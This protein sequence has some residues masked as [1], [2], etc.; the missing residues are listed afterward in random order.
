MSINFGG[1]QLAQGLFNDNKN[2]EIS[3]NFPRKTRSSQTDIPQSVMEKIFSHPE[4]KHT[5]EAHA[6]GLQKKCLD[7]EDKNAKT[8]MLKSNYFKNRTP[9]N[10]LPLNENVY[11][12]NCTILCDALKEA[13]SHGD[14]EYVLA[15][16]E[17]ELKE[18]EPFESFTYSARHC[19][20][21]HFDW[22]P[23]QKTLVLA[24]KHGHHLIVEK[25]MNS[26]WYRDTCSYYR[27][28]NYL[29]GKALNEA[30]GH[31]F[32]N[33]VEEI[34]KHKEDLDKYLSNSELI[35]AIQNSVTKIHICNS[36]KYRE[37][38]DRLI[39]IANERNM[40]ESEYAIET[41]VLG[42]AIKDLSD[43]GLIKAIQNSTTRIHIY[44]SSEYREIKD[45]LIAIANERNIP[46]SEYAIKTH[47]LVVAVEDGLVETAC[48][49]IN[50]PVFN[51]ISSSDLNK[52]WNI[53]CKKKY[54]DIVIKLIE[55]AKFSEINYPSYSFEWEGFAKAFFFEDK[56][57]IR[58]LIASNR[59]EKLGQKLL[60]EI[61]ISLARNHLIAIKELINCSRFQ[62][63]KIDTLGKALLENMK[64]SYDRI[65]VDQTALMLINNSKFQEIS[66]D[67]LGEFLVEAAGKS[68]EVTKKLMD[69]SRFQEIKAGVLAKALKKAANYSSLIVKELTTSNRFTE[70]PFPEI[71]EI[72]KMYA[73]LEDQNNSGL[74]G[75]LTYDKLHK[76]HPE[77]F[78]S[79]LF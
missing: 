77:C 72:I 10:Q 8:V 40:P 1:Q 29:V 6:Y 15:I 37:I 64:S 18:V 79:T 7:N 54:V 4:H 62:E 25:L 61:F 5:L 9:L 50:S 60:N 33:V 67:I 27:D 49:I 43:S 28:E 70:I 30:T 36:S 48:E 12:G 74:E 46:E 41:H 68:V 52:I 11:P 66:L 73:F 56:G 17:S 65:L 53:A 45:R 19:A 42:A 55:S 14:M 21:Y 34:L 3:R 69:N 47:V 24:A 63:I 31:G 2:S 44:N 38:K 13:A 75:L 35:E 51:E 16:L 76:I 26:E 78:R 57:A 22:A 58:A 71:G 39:A 23:L 59:F 20:F 32:Q